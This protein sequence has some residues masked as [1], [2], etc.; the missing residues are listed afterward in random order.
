MDIVSHFIISTYIT[1]IIS[2]CNKSRRWMKATNTD[3]CRT[4]NNEDD[5]MLCR[6]TRPDGSL[7]AAVMIFYKFLAA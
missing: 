4:N 6:S 5:A 2:I 3:C 1:T 7:A